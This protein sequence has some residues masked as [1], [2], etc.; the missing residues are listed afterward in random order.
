MDRR[1]FVA[2]CGMGA[3]AMALPAWARAGQFPGEGAPLYS[4]AGAEFVARGEAGASK[5]PYAPNWPSLSTY[6][7]PD[8]YA[9]AKFG[10]FIHWGVYSVP[11]FMS[12]WYPRMMYQRNNPAYWHHLAAYGPQTKFGYKDFIPHFRAEKFDA[13]VWADLFKKAGARYVVPVAEHHDGFGMYDSSLSDWC[14]AKI[15]PR[16]DI[17]GELGKAV[18]ERGLAFGLSSHRAEHWW[19]YNGGRKFPSDV[20]DPRWQSFYG[21]A[22]P[23]V[24][25]DEAYMRDWFA[26]T[27]ELVEKYDPQVLWFDWWI[28]RPAF[29]PWRQK[30]AAFLYNR[31]A[32]RGTVPVLNYKNKSFPD[33]AAV[34]D[35][36][37]SG[38][39]EIRT[40]LWQTDTSTSFLSWGYVKHNLFK[41]P[42]RIVSDL[43]DTISKN[44]VLLLNIGPRPDGL[45]PDHEQEI[46]RGVGKWLSVNGPG[47]YGSRPWKIYGEGPTAVRQQHNYG[48]GEM[49]AARLTSRDLRFTTRGGKLYAF[50]MDWPKDGKVAVKSLGKKAG[51]AAGPVKGVRL[52]GSDGRVEWSQAD[53]ALAVMLPAARPCE[54][55]VCL[56]VDGVV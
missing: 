9:D 15:G 11:A 27:V 53:E 21:P 55:A 35:L 16:R 5:G 31:G 8:W 28:E 4:P 14:A 10:I 50:V 36:E 48:A 32:E 47:V 29:E 54:Y 18:R 56:E 46:L 37:R 19:F 20:R 6:K 51:L 40:P 3:A 30:I 45:I 22:Q 34:L 42:D 26:R 44:G 24:D 38:L 17:I 52:L 49:A 43:C 39:S 23:E 13:G 1:Q 33:T 12:E 7:I 2:G 41:S 25:P